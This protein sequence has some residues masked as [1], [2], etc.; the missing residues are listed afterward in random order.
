MSEQTSLAVIQEM[1]INMLKKERDRLRE[2][3]KRFANQDNWDDG[4]E[5]TDWA[6]IVWD[7]DGN[8]IEIARA[9]LREEK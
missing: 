5:R 8:P 6:I 9:A 2:A 1:E 7:G 4:D 3:L